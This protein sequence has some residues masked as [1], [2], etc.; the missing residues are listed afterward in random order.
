MNRNANVDQ[1]L[2]DVLRKRTSQAHRNLDSNVS[3]VGAFSS[4]GGYCRY[5]QCMRDLH[6]QYQKPIASVSQHVGLPDNTQTI[7]DSIDKDIEGCGRSPNTKHQQNSA[8]SYD[9][10]AA[11]G[12]AYVLEGS[13]MGAR[14]VVKTARAQL[15][16]GTPT[17]YL[18]CMSQSA[19]ERWPAI[20]KSLS[21]QSCENES[22][23]SAALSVFDTAAGLF[24]D[25]GQ[26]T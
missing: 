13:S 8:V 14:Y 3:G 4:V 1:S 7:L 15:P 10:D 17:H 19:K 16:E 11:L 5:L 18:D 2:R 23:I 22:A 12:I 24:A 9:E 6:A 21:N 20:V 26:T 25:A